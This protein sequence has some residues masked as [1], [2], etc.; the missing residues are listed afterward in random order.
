M[1]KLISKYAVAAHLAF[2]AVSPLVLL[3]FFGSEAIANAI[4]YLTLFGAVWVVMEPSRRKGEH[5]HNARERSAREIFADPL[6]WAVS[7]FVLLAAVRWLN[8]GIELAFNPENFEWYAKDPCVAILPSCVNGSGKIEFA[9]AL[10]ALVIIMGIR[11]STGRSARVAFLFI[12]CVIAAIASIVSVKCVDFGNT[13]SLYSIGC[14]YLAPSWPGTIFG[15]WMLAGV[16]ALSGAIADDWKGLGLVFAF[17]IGGAGLGLFAFAPIAT[18]AIFAIALSITILVSF[19]WVVGQKKGLGAFKFFGMTIVAIAC[20]VILA[21]TMLPDAL[22]SQKIDSAMA[23]EVFPEE[24]LKNRET[25]SSIAAR[26]FKEN[27]WIGTGLGT[28]QIDVRLNAS[29]ADLSVLPAVKTIVNAMNGWLNLAAERGLVG[30]VAFLIPVV[31]LI[32]SFIVKIPGAVFKTVFIPGALLPFISL[33]VAILVGFYDTSLFSSSGIMAIAAFL[34]LASVSI[35]QSKKMTI[36]KQDNKESA[37]SK[38]SDDNNP[39]SERQVENG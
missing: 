1:Q 35:P 28:F 16:V 30:I 12:G 18:I 14:D 25:L 36:S 19:G 23:L 7:F 4:L 13:Q 27:L 9:C 29:R 10:G 5:L 32:V 34:A 24:F 8:S 22:I 6:L 11:H 3:P 33:I 15:F 17:A 21:M 37:E 39:N 26:V 2:I 31:M 38:D 20:G